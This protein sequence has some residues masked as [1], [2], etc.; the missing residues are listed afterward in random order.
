MASLSATLNKAPVTR[1]AHVLSKMIDRLRKEGRAE[2]LAFIE[3]AFKDAGRFDDHLFYGGQ[4]DDTDKYDHLLLQDRK[5]PHIQ[6]MADRL[7]DSFWLANTIEPEKDLVDFANLNA[8]EVRSIKMV[9][10]FFAVADTLVQEY[11]TKIFANEF[12]LPECKEFFMQQVRSEEV[13]QDVYN[14]FLAVFISDKEERKELLNAYSKG[15]KRYEAIRKKIEWIE[16]IMSVENGNLGE[17]VVG[18]IAFEG[19]YFAGQFPLFL[20]Y[21]NTMNQ[22]R[23]SNSYIRR[24][25]SL[26]CDFYIALWKLMPNRPS[27]ARSKELLMEAVD[28]EVQMAKTVLPEDLDDITLPDLQDHIRATA[29][30]W[31]EKMGIE[32]PYM[33]PD[34]SVLRT[35]LLFMNKFQVTTKTNMFEHHETNYKVR[36]T[37]L[38]FEYPDGE[39]FS[40]NE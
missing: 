9:L 26:H 2:D 8:K 7:N 34:G 18:Q 16:K 33:S 11:V 3:E 12:P 40:D 15:G 37:K 14:N 6:R 28:L 35:P 20:K 30:I 17:K 4:T 13:H 10:A 23:T 27:L 21:H 1:V 25:E 31:F 24:D 32:P 19:V 38:T 22:L 39:E 36:N 29:N 5:Y